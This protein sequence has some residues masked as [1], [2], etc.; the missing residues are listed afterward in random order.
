[1]NSHTYFN[2][3]K[4]QL[5]SKYMDENKN[6]A[7]GR[8]L[9]IL[10]LYTLLI[11]RVALALF[12]IPTF[13]ILRS[14]LNI[15]SIFLLLPLALFL[16]LISKGAKGFTYVILIASIFRLIIYFALISD[17]LEQT[18]LTDAYAIILSGVLLIQFFISLFL[19]VSFDCDTYFS[20]VQRI[21]IKV[22][23]EE[24]LAQRHNA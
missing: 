12:E 22:H 20:A 16:F 17:T 3:K 15:L 1:M 13:I 6:A 5:I 24:L 7:R 9:V 21:T 23:G 14:P 11:L 19:L 10:S 8:R 4:A 18:A 2:K